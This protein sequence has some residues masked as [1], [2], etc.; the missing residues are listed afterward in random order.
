M[1][2]ALLIVPL[3]LLATVSLGSA[4]AG[5]LPEKCWGH[6][7]AEAYE[8]YCVNPNDPSCLVSYTF[9]SGTGDETTSCTGLP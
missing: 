3:L 7:V 4:S 5:T 6:P 1:R 9:I 8:E 2:I